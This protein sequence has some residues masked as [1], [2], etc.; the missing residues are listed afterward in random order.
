VLLKDFQQLFII[1]EL[2]KQFNYPIQIIAGETVRET[3]NWH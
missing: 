3:G 1:R 2:V